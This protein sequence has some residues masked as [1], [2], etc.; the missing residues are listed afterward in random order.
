MSANPSE[1]QGSLPAEV[2][3]T[4]PAVTSGR[5]AWTS[6]FGSLFLA[7]TPFALFALLWILDGWIR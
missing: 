5:Q 2:D 6:R 4:G 3:P 7:L 1:A